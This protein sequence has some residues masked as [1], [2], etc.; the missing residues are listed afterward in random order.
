[1]LVRNPRLPDVSG[2][3]CLDLRAAQSC[4]PAGSARR[5]ALEEAAAHA[6]RNAPIVIPDDMATLISFE[7]V[8][9]LTALSLATPDDLSEERW[10]GLAMVLIFADITRPDHEA[11][12]QMLTCTASRA[13]SALLRVLPAALSA[14][15]ARW[16]ANA[17]NTLVGLVELGPQV[18]KVVLDWS[19]DPG[20]TTEQWQEAMRVLARFERATLP[21]LARLSG[22]SFP[23]S[24]DEDARLTLPP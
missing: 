5:A 8:P 20:R 1:M 22:C 18:N 11:R 23:A 12:L 14:V 10:A 2:R 13:G 4:P 3:F 17:V 6:L 9:E 16:M 19:T 21:A 15:P 7:E 24:G